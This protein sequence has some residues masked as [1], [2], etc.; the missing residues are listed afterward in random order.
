MKITGLTL[1]DKHLNL[2]KRRQKSS[3]GEFW[4]SEGF[5]VFT[6]WCVQEVLLALH[7]EF[8][9]VWLKIPKI[10]KVSLGAKQ[11]PYLLYCCSG[12]ILDILNE[13]LIVY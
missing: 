7:S 3:F 10:P 8:T 4:G 2:G 5:A 13:S 11:M 12:P 1:N 6:P 9:S